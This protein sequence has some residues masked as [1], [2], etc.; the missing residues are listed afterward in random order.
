MGEGNVA[1]RSASVP[2]ESVNGGVLSELQHHRPLRR[3][4]Q[5]RR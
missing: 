3:S 5:Y 4:L 1:R 2:V